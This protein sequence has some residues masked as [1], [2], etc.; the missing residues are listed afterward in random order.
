MKN[1]RLIC[2]SIFIALVFN[3]LN[4]APIDTLKAKQVGLN[5]WYAY[6]SDKK[7]D[8][9]DVKVSK[10]YIIHEDLEPVYYVF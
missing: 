6:A 10:T 8:R 2:V 5:F 9:S 1:L 3:K 7:I 4:A